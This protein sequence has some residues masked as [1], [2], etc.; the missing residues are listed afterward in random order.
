MA[1]ERNFLRV[2]PDSTG[3]RVR[4]KHTAQILYTGLQNNH[5]WIVDAMYRTT[6]S[7]GS[8]YMIHVHGHKG[9][10]ST[11]GILEVHYNST[12][13]YNNLSPNIGAGILA[14]DGSTVATVS[15]VRDVYVNSNHIIGYDNPEHGLNIDVTGSANIRFAEG[16]P[17][18]DAFG[19]LRTSGATLLGEYTFANSYLPEK[20]STAQSHMGSTIGWDSNARAALLTLDGNAGSLVAHTTNTYHHYFP[21]S[22]HLFMATLALG[23]TGKQGLGR[24]WGLFDFQNGLHFVHKD[25]KLGVVIKKDVTG[26]TQD[27]YFWQDPGVGEA[28]WNGD[29]LDGTGDSGMD[30]D[31]TKDNL[32]WID[33]QWL[34]AGRAR[35]GVYYNGQRV[36]VHEYYHGNT[37]PYPL[38][39]TASLPACFAQRN[40]T[41]TGSTSEMRVYCCAVWTETNIEP[42]NYGEPAQRS[43]DKIIPADN[44]VYQYIGTMAPIEKYSNGRVN[45]SIYYPTNLQVMA[46]DTVTGNPVKVEVEVKVFS[47]LSDLNFQPINNINYTVEYDTAGT[48][49][50]GGIA[51]YKAFVDGKETF[52]L[53]NVYNNM[54]TGAVKNFSEKGGHKMAMIQ[55]IT[56]ASPAVITWAASEA[57]FRE[58]IPAVSEGV[59]RDT[60][61]IFIDDAEGMTQ[62]NSGMTT[63]YYLKTIALNQ[64]EIYTDKNLTVP[65]DTTGY[66]VYTAGSGYAHGYYGS[67]FYWTLVAK[68]YFGTNSARVICKVGWKEIRQ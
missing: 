57:P 41:A 52:D 48:Y 36:V 19:K 18:L 8:V 55:N 54:T 2:P 25:G 43:L 15:E 35:F 16:L 9:L 63:K 17:Q 31:V 46:F 32:Y 1:G 44:D 28:G 34:G 38:T 56:N 7:D 12:P 33:V 24:S 66:G 14:P 29:P 26:S 4:L 50:G 47:V 10:T 61:H 22:S 60:M 51:I 62:I 49:Y 11:T 5:F 64:S 65:L 6:F 58:T 39:A 27:L 59:D 45:R 13:T 37:S 42:Q 68:K 30:I 21:G 67:Q 20:F 40:I 53:T 3:K 23:D